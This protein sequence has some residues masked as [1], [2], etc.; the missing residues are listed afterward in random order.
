M[1]RLVCIIGTDGSGKSTLGQAVA[2]ELTARG[3]S[4]RVVWLGAE[5][6]LMAPI[7]RLLRFAWRARSQTPNATAQRD[8]PA[9]MRRD[10]AAE[11]ARKTRLA[12]RYGWAVSIYI[13]LVWLDYR[14][15]LWVKHRR[16]RDVA[17]IVAD[18]YIFDVAVN[19]GLTLGWSP[20]RV[21]AFLRSKLATCALPEERV[22]L[23]V[24]P[25]V[26]LARKDDVYDIDYLR[27]RLTYYDAI[28][29]AFG[30]QIRE[31]TRPIEE[32]RDWLIARL[33]S[34]PRHVMY[35][36]SNNSDIGG[37]DKMMALMA[38]HTVAASDGPAR[39]RATACL[40]LQTAILGEYAR[41]GIPV[42][43]A[44]FVRP[45]LSRG[46]FGVLRGIAL[47][48]FSLWVLWRLM[49]R[50]RPDLVHVN[51]LYDVLPALAARLRGIPVIWHIRMIVPRAGVRRVFAT[52]VR[53]LSGQS[54]SVSDA[55]RRHYFPEP[56]APHAPLV[57]HDLGNSALT[58][59][60]VSEAPRTPRPP[61]LPEHGRLVVMVG[62][63]EWWKGQ[64]V[65]VDAVARLPEALRKAHVFALIGGG[66]AGKDAYLD[67]VVAR[68]AEAGVLVLGERQDVPDLLLSAD[69]SVHASVLPDPFPG[70]VIEGL[71]AG[72]ATVAAKA[73]GALEMITPG[74][75][76]LLVAPGDAAGL[77]EA[78]RD[79]LEAPQPP[80]ARFGQAG[81]ARA[82]AL[83]DARAID[84]RIL[85]T[86]AA[87]TE[88]R[89]REMADLTPDAPLTKAEKSRLIFETIGWPIGT[90]TRKPAPQQLETLTEF[91]FK[92]RVGL[93]FLD[94]CLRKGVELGPKA[95]A[96]HASLMARRAATDRVIVKLARRLD[97]VA[98]G[99]WVLFK[100]I[101]PFAATP[102]DTDWFP[103][104][105][106]RHRGL[107]D[108]LCAEGHGFKLME[109]A[110]L[111]WTLIED[112]GIDITDTTK[113]GGIYYI[114]CYVAP[115]TDYFIYLDPARMR[116][117]VEMTR[118][119]GYDVPILQ[120]HAELTAI[121]FHNVF[122]EKSFSIE[123]Y[124]LVKR[125]LDLIEAAGTLDAFV[126]ACRD[127]KVE[128][129]C[130]VNLALT[131]DIDA[132]QFGGNDPRI[133]RL[134]DALGYG[135][136]T[137]KG[138]DPFG[139]FPY[140]IPAKVFWGA[141]LSKQ[142]DR[143]ALRSTG[144][145][146]LHMLNP[147]FFADVVRVVYRRTIKGGV[148]EQN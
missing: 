2:A 94:E 30:F 41:I 143:T 44:P 121:M 43:H 144:N 106:A 114:D 35:V 21:I 72:T 46:I 133:A 55:V 14:L 105:A 47:A 70:T 135:D 36:H 49:G 84:A 118:I 148:Y 128:Y 83:T 99:E 119:D 96:L 6:V 61:P 113:K 4:A 136:L 74:R 34:P 100:S 147:I 145:Q 109:K 90:G 130:A 68:A 25:E 37:A 140:A 13:W 52:L 48:P 10:Y 75:D 62:R 77:S 66:V 82:L 3:N 23:R 131:R 91:A 87:A 69:I 57:I 73:G 117:S 40:R 92:S 98:R 111:Q 137:I 110:P 56:V 38:Q 59:A 7:R 112:G 42:I 134:L 116:D 126:T 31:G 22:F 32:T 88:G 103:F 85:A 132:G 141:F 146:F 122:P 125:Y 115:S 18:R 8:G 24:A 93:L 104:D 45:Q 81:R 138:F 39:W 28:A 86:Y 50:E 97:E 27:L 58:K 129:A 120:P 15:Q 54:I 53:Q 33:L 127:Q 108:H 101:K 11:I 71:L 89:T 65:F 20:K 67:D 124:Y 107:V 26:S 9:S 139:A 60:E 1:A 95:R 123:S 12:E 102:N 17:I 78:L 5:S 80:R 29:Q 16:N 51:D 64:H 19:L 79:L 76:G 142:R 63:I